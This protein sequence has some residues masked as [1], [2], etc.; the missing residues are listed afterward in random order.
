MSRMER[1]E[2]NYFA[3]GGRQLSC[4]VPPSHPTTFGAVSGLSLPGAGLVL[5]HRDIQYYRETLQMCG[6]QSRGGAGTGYL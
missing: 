6:L 3:M 1:G 4:R 2:G 5:A